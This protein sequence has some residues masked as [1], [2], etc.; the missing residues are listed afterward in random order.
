MDKRKD[1]Q[2]IQRLWLANILI[3]LG[4]GRTESS[5]PTSLTCAECPFACRELVA[6]MA[7]PAVLRYLLGAEQHRNSGEQVRVPDYLIIGTQKG[8]TSDLWARLVT[9]PHFKRG[10]LLPK[11]MHFFDGCLGKIQS[12]YTFKCRQITLN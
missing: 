3:V 8:G 2:I 1:V 4:T 6:E 12:C 11:E 10:Q 7:N 9:L 5:A